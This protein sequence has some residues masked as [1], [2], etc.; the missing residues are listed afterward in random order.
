MGGG[1]WVP[2]GQGTVAGP[3][4]EAESGRYRGRS[5]DGRELGAPVIVTGRRADGTGSSAEEVEVLGRCA[6]GWL[7]A[8][9]CSTAYEPC[10]QLL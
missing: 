8:V 5:G 10:A 3:A 4:P 1:V 7:E 2:P 6:P 9:V